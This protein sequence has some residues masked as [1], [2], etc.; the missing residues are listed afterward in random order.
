MDTSALLAHH[1]VSAVR[2]DLLQLQRQGHARRLNPQCTRGDVFI[3]IVLQGGGTLGIA[4]VGVLYALELLQVRTVGVAGTS[5]GAIAALLIAAA[6]KDSTQLYA[7]K[8]LQVLTSMPANEFIDGPYLVRRFIKELLL[9]RSLDFVELSPPGWRALDRLMQK[10]GLNPGTAFF[11]WLRGVLADRFEVRTIADLLERLGTTLA[12][13]KD[14]FSASL[15]PGRLI[16]APGEADPE[17]ALQMVATGLP[18]GMKIVFPRQRSLFE[19]DTQSTSPAMFARA[20]MSIPFFFEP[21]QLPLN[22]RGWNAMLDADPARLMYS[23]V[24]REQLRSLD[25]IHFVDGGVLSNFPMDAFSAP[26]QSASWVQQLPTIGFSM[27]SRQELVSTEAPPVTKGAMAL[28]AMCMQMFSATRALRDREARAR[29]TLPSRIAFI[30]TGE[31]NW[32]NFMLDDDSTRDLFVRGMKCVVEL[33][34]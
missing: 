6:R 16:T 13:A 4:H 17:D 32:L 5:A 24:D 11:E 15:E 9:Q 19:M 1:Q 12:C 30:D 20:S 22:V 25:A 18:H 2:T 34:R 8:L 33:V 28:G 31:H 27:I 29:C 23:E 10:R 14:A 3:N 26:P 7:E 21:L